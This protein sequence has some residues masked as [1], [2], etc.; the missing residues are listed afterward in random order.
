AHAALRRE[1]GP[2][3]MVPYAALRRAELIAATDRTTA[4]ELAGRATDDARRIGATPLADRAEALLRRLGAGEVPDDA[5][6]SVPGA[7]ALTPRELDVLRL[8]ADGRSNGE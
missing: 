7:P 5:P 1:E 4:I 2:A 6:A 3:V 8:V